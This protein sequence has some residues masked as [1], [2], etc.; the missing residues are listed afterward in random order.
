MIP[1]ADGIAAMSHGTS[2]LCCGNIGVY[3]VAIFPD[4]FPARLRGLFAV[5]G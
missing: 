1:I 3:L 5:L 4:L 2:A